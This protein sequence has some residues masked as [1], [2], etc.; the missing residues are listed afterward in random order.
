MTAMR[1]ARLALPGALATFAAAVTLSAPA[2]AQDTLVISTWGFNGDLLE[3]HLFAPFEAEHGVDIV[4]ETGNNADRLNKVQIR[5]GSEIDLIYLASPFAQL[6]V[7]AGVFAEIDRSMIPNLE[8]IYELAQAPHGEAYGPAYSVG[9]YGIIYDTAAVETPITSWE[10]LWR[11]EFEGRASIPDI[12]TT[13]GALLVIYAGER[14]GV[15]AF[16]DPDAAFASLAELAPNV[17]TTYNRS[18]VLA[19]MF[20]Q[21]EVVVAAAQDFVFSRIQESVPTA[22]WAELDEGAFANLNTI[23]IIAGSDQIELA[24]TF[25]NW[26]LSEGTQTALA[27][28]AVDAPINT[29]VE[30]TPEQAAIWTYGADVIA[31]LR[32]VDPAAIAGVQDAWITRWNETFRQ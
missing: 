4:L 12:N 2:S 13:A 21:G 15:D 19:N 30:L 27:V 17:L 14:V 5:G 25:I 6:G 29:N 1:L 10:D 24:H 3:E 20:A 16:E 28:A 22:A 26:A 7:D 18:S 8:Q 11:P 32:T 23:N 9:R 31:S